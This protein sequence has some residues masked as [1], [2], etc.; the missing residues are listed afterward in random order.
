MNH[1]INFILTIFITFFAIECSIR[2][3]NKILVCCG[4]ESKKQ[5][6]TIV[7]TIILGYFGI[8]SMHRHGFDAYNIECSEINNFHSP[9]TLFFCGLLVGYFLHD[10]IFQKPSKEYIFHH[11]LGTI[12]SLAVVF[13][14]Y[15]VSAYYYEILLILE[16]TNIFLNMYYLSINTKII[17]LVSMILFASSFTVIRVMYIPVIL[18]RLIKCHDGSFYGLN[19]YIYNLIIV[20]T[21]ILYALNIFWYCK[22]I[23]KLMEIIIK[24]K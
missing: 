4:Y 7:Q 20:N 5:V 3:L 15:H 9:D 1:I 24:R 14:Q 10:T 22:I 18:F 23:N 19:S 11:I 13:T 16:I 12:A 2:I 17:K 21:L 6:V 8:K